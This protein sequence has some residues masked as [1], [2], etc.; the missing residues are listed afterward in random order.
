MFKGRELTFAPSGWLYDVTFV[1][2]DHQTES[3]WYPHEDDDGVI[4][5]TAIGGYYMGETIVELESETT[6]WVYWLRGH[7]DSKYMLDIL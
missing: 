4:R 7:P 6:K 1:L 2:Y 5:I 3:L